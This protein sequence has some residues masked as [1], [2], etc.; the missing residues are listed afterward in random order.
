MAKKRQRQPESAAET[1]DAIES[2]GD[3]IARRVGEN[4]MPILGTAVGILVIAAIFGLTRDFTMAQSS[5]SAAALA[6]VLSEYRTSMGASAGAIEVPEPANPETARRIR[7]ETI[8][9]LGEVAGEHEGSAAAALALLEAGKLYQQLGDNAAATEQF[10]QGLAEIEPGHPIRG[11]L[12]MRLGSVYE[13]EGRWADAAAAY[14]KAANVPGNPL[15]YDALA[16]AARSYS[17][18]GDADQA[19]AAYD[20]IQAEAPEYRL[21][22]Y[23]EARLAELDESTAAGAPN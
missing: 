7:T 20:L 15:R 2:F 8:T 22:P 21:A 10:E 14:E 6:R 13:A 3:R 5:E 17:Q 23:V 16:D 11:F 1:L 19:R 4:P 18:A 9:A 12:E